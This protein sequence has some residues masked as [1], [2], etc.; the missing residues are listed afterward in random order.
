MCCD[1]YWR[2]DAGFLSWPSMIVII[3]PAMVPMSQRPFFKSSENSNPLQSIT[4]LFRTRIPHINHILG[5]SY[6]FAVLPFP[7]FLSLSRANLLHN[8]ISWILFVLK[9][10]QFWR[11]LSKDDLC[12]E[13]PSEVHTQSFIYFIHHLTACLAEP[14]PESPLQ[15][16]TRKEMSKLSCTFPNLPQFFDF[17]W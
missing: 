5:I 16:R 4:K 8:S 14:C 7:L 3:F 2:Q 11:A 10:H 1:C 13:M 17:W 9:L 6:P 15:D 12:C